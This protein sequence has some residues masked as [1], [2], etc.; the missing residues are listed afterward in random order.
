MS[1]ELAKGIVANLGGTS[2]I[3]SVTHCA[4]RLRFQLHDF[5]KADC[6]AL[7]QLSGVADAFEGQGQLQLIIGTHVPDVYDDVVAIPG[8]TD[9]EEAV[10]SAASTESPRK[11]KLIDR[12]LAAISAIFT[13]Y[14]PLLASVGIIKGLLAIAV[15]FDW[16]SETSN[17]YAILA[18]AGNAVIYFFPILLAFTAA[19]RFGANPYIGA[20]I[21]A[22]L[23]E[24]NLTAINETGA[25]LDFLGI[26]FTGQSFGGTVLPIIVGMWAFAYLERGL[27]KIL[28]QMTHL[29]LIPVISLLIMVPATL[30]VFG[31]VGFAIANGIAAAYG[32]LVNF[33][34]L[35][36][37]I[38]GGFFIYVIM[39]GVHW[40]VLPIQLSIL[41][42]NGLEYSLA[43]GGMGNYAVL[44]V[45]LAVLVTSRDRATR[46]V[47]GS[48][49]FV[50]AIAG[51]TEPGIFGVIVKRKRYFAA[52]TLG[53]MAGGLV[54][55]IF[56]VYVTAFAFSG[57]LGAPAFLAS[58]KAAPYF[59]AVAISIVSAFVITFIM[60]RTARRRDPVEEQL[61]SDPELQAA[62]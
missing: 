11:L 2:N 30:L 18:A 3:S 47:A 24:P 37:V 6:D 51:V 19:K 48:S 58:P 28:P 10:S 60:E 23:L 20:T 43:S 4:T 52:V 21:G 42:E 16:L 31:P 35:L 39:L 54:C 36:H 32:W 9:S 38:F 56:S 22:A 44:G 8:V 25:E 14:I 62:V 15:N 34:I 13:P 55:G 41:A 46:T 26:G 49:A 33:P 29:L 40:I 1:T 7:A 57:V 27:K 12:I 17:T 45:L 61:S 5:S 53:G 59:L 50:N